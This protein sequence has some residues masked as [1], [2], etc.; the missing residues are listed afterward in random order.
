MTDW[1]ARL[2][3]FLQA[4]SWSHPTWDLFIV[5]FLMVGTLVYGFSLGRDR[6]IMIMVAVYM[7][8]VAVLYLPVIPQFTAAF[9]FSNGFA[10]KVGTFLGMFAV[11]FFMLTRSALNRS[12]SGDGALGRWWHVLILSFLQVGMLVSVVVG[13]LPPLWIEKLSPITQLIFASA[14]GKFVWV[15][16]PIFGL[17]LVG[18]SNER[19]RMMYDR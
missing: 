5:V 7:A 17:L 19:T 3:E 14:W 11:L 2:N 13:F 12:L 10:F 8:L 6:I 16:A 1:G 15:V 18:L 9:S 4:L